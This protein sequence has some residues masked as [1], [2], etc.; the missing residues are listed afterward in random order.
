MPG[1]PQRCVACRRPFHPRYD[2]CP[3]CQHAVSAPPPKPQ[4][5][6]WTD[7]ARSLLT[8]PGV[9]FVGRHLY[10]WRSDT[11]RDFWM[12]VSSAVPSL[13][14][15]EWLLDGERGYGCAS[16]L[17]LLAI[18]DR[19]WPSSDESAMDWNE[20]RKGKLAL[21][22]PSTV[23]PRPMRDREGCL[24]LLALEMNNDRAPLEGRASSS[25]TRLFL[26]RSLGTIDTDMHEWIA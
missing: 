4:A 23:W 1:E 13:P 24:C 3:F 6:R 15:A 9:F 18:Y 26:L 7:S 20:L 10:H 21:A 14:E 8:S 5:S 11:E 16:L 22:S 2:V 19:P 17:E 25:K 12:H